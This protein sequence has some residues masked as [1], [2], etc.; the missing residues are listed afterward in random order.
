MNTS[1]NP[2]KENLVSDITLKNKEFL[3]VTG[4]KKVVSL[5][6]EEFNLDTVLGPLLIKGQML[7]MA[8]LDIDNGLISIKGQITT[9]EY[10]GKYQKTKEKSFL[11]K[12]F[13]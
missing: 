10:N 7:E 11:A 2:N 8:H 12:V 4:V 3:N 1:I 13:R 9:I 5:N 6:K